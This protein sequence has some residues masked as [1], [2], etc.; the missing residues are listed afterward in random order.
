MFT[1]FIQ[2]D[3]C[4]V[5]PRKRVLLALAKGSVCSMSRRLIN[6]LVE[7]F[8]SGDSQLDISRWQGSGSKDY[9][10]YLVG[11]SFVQY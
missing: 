1:L 9:V 11:L 8:Q 7:L 5:V 3:I 10:V 4:S 6:Q 2:S